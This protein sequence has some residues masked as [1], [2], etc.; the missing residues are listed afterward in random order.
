MKKQLIWNGYS[1]MLC[2]KGCL[3]LAPTHS[4]HVSMRSR[5]KKCPPFDSMAREKSEVEQEM[6]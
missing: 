1:G 5:Q 4:V 3:E 6:K 2:S